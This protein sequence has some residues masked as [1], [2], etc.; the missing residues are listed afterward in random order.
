MG[1]AQGSTTAVWAVTRIGAQLGRALAARLDG[2]LMAPADLADEFGAQAYDALLPAVAA[3]FADH[4]RHVFVAASGIVVRA[5]ARLLKGKAVDPAVVVVD[6]RGRFAVSLVSGHLGGANDLAREV[7]AITAGTPV[8]T[9]ATDVEDLPA[10]D[11]LARERG[12][13][14]AD[15][16]AIK[17]VNVAVLAGDVIQVLD[18]EGRLGLADAPEDWRERFNL[19]PDASAWVAGHPGVWVTWQT[20]EPTTF[21]PG[22][23]MLVLHPCCLAV[24]VG[25]RRGASTREILDAVTGVLDD[26]GL[27]MASVMGLA[28]IAAKSDEPGLLE[29]AGRL[30]RGLF[31]YDA[32]T[33]ARMDV[34]NTS[35]TVEKHMGVGSVSEAAALRLAGGGSLPA[36]LLV[37]KCIRGNVTVAVALAV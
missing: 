2:T 3:R 33:L 6:Q 7:A 36:S 12:L 24:G 8:I 34:A 4:R 14:V 18:P 13:T 22:G 15:V 19:L 26:N 27:A 31:F 5:M 23:D 21:N 11:Q 37:E 20:M 1:D 29:A 9:T 30:G 17:P 25:C 28:S 35:E 16:A 32:E 10:M